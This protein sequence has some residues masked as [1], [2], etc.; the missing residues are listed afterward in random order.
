MINHP[1][2]G[3]LEACNLRGGLSQLIELCLDHQENMVSEY[4]DLYCKSNAWLLQHSEDLIIMV[5]QGAFIS[6][7]VAVD[8]LQEAVS[9]LDIVINRGGDLKGK[10]LTMKESGLKYISRLKG[11]EAV[12]A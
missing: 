7:E 11:K 10:A 12:S 1:Q 9:N 2:P 4:C 3:D 6:R 5:G 8:R